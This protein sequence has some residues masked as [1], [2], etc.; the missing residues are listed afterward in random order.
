VLLFGGPAY[1]S[2]KSGSTPCVWPLGS[3]RH[4]GWL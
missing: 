4:R 1:L 2:Q 3:R